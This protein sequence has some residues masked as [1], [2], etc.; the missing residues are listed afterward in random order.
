[1]QRTHVETMKSLLIFA[2]LKNIIQFNV[3][4]IVILKTD[5]Q[6]A[7][8]WYMCRYGYISN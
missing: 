1:M 8:V 6:P 7:L 3:V 4:Q 2:Y 5:Y